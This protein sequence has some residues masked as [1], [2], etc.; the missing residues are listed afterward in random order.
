MQLEDFNTDY[1]ILLMSF[2][3]ALYVV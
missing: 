1:S 2:V 3:E